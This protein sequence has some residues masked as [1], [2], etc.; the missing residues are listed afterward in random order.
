MKRM[1][2]PIAAIVAAFALGFLSHAL[3]ERWRAP[4]EAAPGAVGASRSYPVTYVPSADPPPPA[5]LPLVQATDLRKLRQLAGTQAR[6][7]GRVY[8][9]GHSARSNTYFLNFGP[10]RGAF[11]GVIFA[12]A[13]E[14][15]ER[16]RI[17][18]LSYEGREVEIFGQ[19]KDHP[20]YGLE[21]ILED[22]S[23]IRVLN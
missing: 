19:I 22:P 13:A 4:Q 12:S 17:N 3:Y 6:V 18:P 8:R 5:E 11:T 9:V 21:M 2:G 16:R 10:A 23:S 15:F 7:R 14:L 20:T 1:T